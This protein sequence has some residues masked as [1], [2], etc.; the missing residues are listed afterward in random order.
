ML[1]V[2]HLFNEKKEKIKKKT[3]VIKKRKIFKKNFVKRKGFQ[4]KNIN[5]SKESLIL[6][7]A[8]IQNRLTTFPRIKFS[9]FSTLDKK[10]GSF[11]T[12]I[13]KRI[14]SYKI[15]REEEKQK[16]IIKRLEKEE[17]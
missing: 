11:F 7:I 5:K 10:I 8:R 12:G 1:V 16:N 6:K 4:F 15:L 3:K 14:I 2:K 13:E 9:F 17:K